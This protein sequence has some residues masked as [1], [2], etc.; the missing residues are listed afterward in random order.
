VV[1]ELL[2]KEMLEELLLVW[3]H[4]QLAVVVVQEV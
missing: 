2:A 4:L 1:L 3:F